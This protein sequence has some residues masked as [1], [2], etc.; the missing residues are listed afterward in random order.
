[1][2]LLSNFNTCDIAKFLPNLQQCVNKATHE[3]GNTLDK[4]FVNIPNSYSDRYSPPLGKSDHNVIHLFPK[5]KQ[6]VKREAPTI[7]TVQQWDI[8]TAE[9]LRGC[10]EATDWNVFFDNENDLDIISDSITSYL[11]FCEENIVPKKE[12]KVYANTKSWINKDI[13]CFLSAKKNILRR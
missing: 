12:I 2:I 10:F 1:M 11:L 8:E 9:T 4:C 13:R 3:K 7:R 5:Y 6:L